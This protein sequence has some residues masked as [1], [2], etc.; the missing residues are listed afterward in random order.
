MFAKR[1][2]LSRLPPLD[3]C[4]RF[5]TTETTVTWYFGFKLDWKWNIFCFRWRLQKAFYTEASVGSTGCK[6]IGCE[7]I[8]LVTC[9]SA[10]KHE[11][12]SGDEFG[13]LSLR[14]LEGIKPQYLSNIVV[15]EWLLDK[16]EN[17]AKYELLIMSPTGIER[18]DRREDQEQFENKLDPG[19]V[20]LSAAMATSA[21]AVA[22]NMGAYDKSMQSLK[23]LQTVLG[24]GLGATMVSDVEAL[25]REP[26]ILRVS[27]A[28]C[29]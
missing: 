13:P 2:Y 24:L 14:D 26:C 12:L 1:R 5:A 22:R 25:K 27:T 3:W 8:F 15:N 7:D 11:P 18:L 23:H 19:D 28:I 4:A 17:E 21:A 16:S 9:K 10:E 29:E 20:D 6:G